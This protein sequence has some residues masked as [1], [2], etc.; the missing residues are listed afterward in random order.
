MNKNLLKGP[1]SLNNFIGILLRF[2]RG[3]YGVMVDIEQMF[4]QI[5]VRS[6][7]RDALQFLWRNNPFLPISEFFMNV[8][9]FGKMDSPCCANWTLKRTLNKLTLFFPMFPFDPKRV[10]L[11]SVNYYTKR[12]I[13]AVLTRCYMDDYLHLFSNKE[14]VINVS[15]KAKQLLSNEGF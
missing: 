10:K 2:R 4:H 9:L 6:K 11:N 13:D 8:H 7:D 1:D 5:Y 15:A 14:E 3:R 12:V